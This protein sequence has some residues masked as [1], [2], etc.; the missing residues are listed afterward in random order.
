[1]KRKSLVGMNDFGA[2][3][4]TNMIEY[5]R[6]C[7]YSCRRLGGEQLN[8]SGEGINYNKYILIVHLLSVVQCDPD[9]EFQMDYRTHK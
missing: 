2:S 3:E 8:T 5:D 1:M 6:R 7:L 9:E 4:S